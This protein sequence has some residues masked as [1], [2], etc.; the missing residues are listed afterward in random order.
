[1]TKFAW[2]KLGKM[3]PPAGVAEEF[4][5]VPFA[6]TSDEFIRVYFSS[7]G[8]SDSDGKFMSFGAFVDLLPSKN[9]DEFQLREGVTTFLR[10][11]TCGGFDDFGA[12]PGSTVRI[13]N[14]TRIYYCGWQRPKDRPYKWSI[15]IAEQDSD[16]PNRH[17]RGLGPVV[18]S[19]EFE[20]AACPIVFSDDSGL[21]MFFLGST[22]WIVDPESNR[23]ESTYLLYGARSSDGVHWLVDDKP[24]VA[25]CV[26]H[27]SQ[28]SATVLVDDDGLHLI[29]SYRD[30]L[31]FRNTPGRG[32]RL[33]YAFST[34][35]N[36]WMRADHLVNLGTSESGWD[37]EMVCYPS[38]FVWNK[39]VY[40]LYSGNSFGR[41][42]FG[43]AR[44]VHG[45]KGD[46]SVL[47]AST[48]F[49]HGEE[50]SHA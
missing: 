20:L 5:Q 3:F 19:K 26:E 9:D 16:K 2:V 22:E 46:V 36:V 32:Y 50:S 48:A 41:F 33:G 49:V 6:V 24:L 23:L 35:G 11:G 30:G 14:R 38:A 8:E 43:L 7:R 47:T 17:A 28:T 44:L 21:R 27:E 12:M 18:L 29:F 31:G 40:L 25:P 39:K 37:S 34:D 4:G 42:G 1:M 13:K 15:G 10:P 45:L